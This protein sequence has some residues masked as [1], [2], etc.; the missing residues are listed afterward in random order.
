[1]QTIADFV[2]TLPPLLQ[3]LL[4]IFVTLCIFRCLMAIVDFIEDKREGK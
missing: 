1:M 4:G 2:N 3:L